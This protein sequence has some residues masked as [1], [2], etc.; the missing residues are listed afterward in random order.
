MIKCIA[1]FSGGLDS[2][3]AVHLLKSQGVYVTALHF[4]L[5][6]YSGTGNSYQKLKDRASQLDVPLRIEEEG[7]DFLYMIK[8]PEFGYG[9][10]ANPCIDCRIYRLRK[11][12][13]IMDETGASFIATGEVVGQRPMSQRRDCLDI[14]EK[15]AGLGGLLLRPLSAKLLRPTVPEEKG[16]VDREK[17]LAIGGRSRKN[18]LDYAKKSGLSYDSPAGGCILTYA[19]TAMRFS[20]LQK[21]KPDFNINDFKLIAY[22]RHFRLLPDL[23][24]VIARNDNE[25][26]I[27]EKLFLPDDYQ[28]FNEDVPGPLSLLRGNCCDKS[29]LELACSIAARY[30]KARSM[31]EVRISVSKNGNKEYIKIKPATDYECCKYR[32]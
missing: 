18:Q 23:W 4:V 14:I 6:F 11:A 16:W 1:M 30:G 2:A 12:R 26:C 7:E 24:L 29:L 13:R 17:F 5:P 19:E 9:K 22:A 20:D 27:L 32:V 3:I 21:N 25:N 10:N 15:K 8:S 28:L 31:D